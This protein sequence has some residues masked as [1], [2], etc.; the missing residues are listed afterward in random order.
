MYHAMSDEEFN[1]NEEGKTVSN[2]NTNGNDARDTPGSYNT[3]E[4]T[5]AS[6]IY[7]SIVD[8][9]V[10]LSYYY[11]S[12]IGMVVSAYLLV[13][14]TSVSNFIALF[15]ILAFLLISGSGKATQPLWYGV[16]RILFFL[17]V[18]RGLALWVYQAHSIQLLT[19]DF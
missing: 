16:W 19:D 12:S 13:D 2:P 17:G 9:F 3:P 8:V 11:G 1:G 6:G 18:I 15:C 5:K 4:G 10:Y 7:R 14:E